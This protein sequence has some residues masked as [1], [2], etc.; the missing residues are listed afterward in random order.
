[1][2]DQTFAALALPFDLADLDRMPA[3]VC[4]LSSDLRVAYVNPAWTAFGRANGAPQDVERWARGADLLAAT[5]PVLRPFFAELFARARS[6]NQPV[7]HE[8]ECSSPDVRRVF[9]MLAH[10]CPSGAF[11]VVH[12]LLREGAP[13]EGAHAALEALYRDRRGMIV[14]C[15]CCRRVRRA[16]IADDTTA[17]WDWVPSYVAKI[18]P[19]TSHGLCA[20]CA[21]YYY[22][23]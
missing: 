21:R 9:R 3:E 2:L 1:M 18:P 22:G 6:T 10:P 20:V 4:G 11:V 14:Q 17:H 8:Y 16:A 23:C 13:E 19:D 7:A 12:S 5:P 15:S